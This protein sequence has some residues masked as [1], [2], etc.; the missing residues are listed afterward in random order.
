MEVKNFGL[1]ALTAIFLGKRLSK[2]AKIS[3]WDKQQLTDAQI[4]YAACDAAV[5]LQIY[6]AM[7]SK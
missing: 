4:T 7:M 5:G 6:D 1:R 2:A 3:N